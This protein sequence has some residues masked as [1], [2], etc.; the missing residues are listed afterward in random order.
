MGIFD[1]IRKALGGAREP[2]APARPGP[3]EANLKSAQQKRRA[4][5]VERA[6]SKRAS[7][8]KIGSYERLE[9][10]LALALG[11]FPWTSS[12]ARD[13]LRAKGFDPDHAE[14]YLRS[15]AA[16]KLLEGER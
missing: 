11:K 3:H 16:R 9:R 15:P 14:A 2:P 1:D 13:A 8:G 7:E 5:G 12:E 10:H 4:A 6:S